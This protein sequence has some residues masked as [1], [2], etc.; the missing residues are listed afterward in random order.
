MKLKFS[1]I[2]LILCVL[3]TCLQSQL[4]DALVNMPN[5]RL[6]KPLVQ[7]NNK[8][9]T[10]NQPIN[11]PGSSLFQ[12]FY[13]KSEHKLTNTNTKTVNKNNSNQL[14]LFQKIEKPIDK[15]KTEETHLSN[16]NRKSFRLSDRISNKHINRREIDDEIQVFLE[17]SKKISTKIKNNEKT[18]SNLNSRIEE[19]D[20]KNNSIKNEIKK[21][22][23]LKKEKKSLES[24]VTNIAEKYQDEVKNIKSTI[25]NKSQFVAKTIK[26]KERNFQNVYKDI[27]SNYSN[28]QTQVDVVKE[29]LQEIVN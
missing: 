1:I 23:S 14:S 2:I 8:P 13:Q 17:K 18:L 6:N 5:I 10:N 3:F 22:K 21:Y 20:E 11:V 25:L 24:K 29:K 19:L 9:N 4:F 7:I 26:D 27:V 15:L 12:N 28:L 16:H